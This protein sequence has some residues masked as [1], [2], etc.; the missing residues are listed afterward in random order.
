MAAD[1]RGHGYRCNCEPCKTYKK[2]ASRYE[3]RVRREYV[4]A[5]RSAS[6]NAWVRARRDSH[7]EAWR[8]ARALTHVMYC[9]C[10]D[11]LKWRQEARER[12]YSS[13]VYQWVSLEND[14][15]EAF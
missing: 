3:E 4:W 14:A 12:A 13:W 8:L 5:L 6:H 15:P 9:Q 10:P 2:Y 11:A 1:V 7:V